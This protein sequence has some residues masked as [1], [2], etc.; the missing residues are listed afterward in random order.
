[1]DWDA[2]LMAVN[3]DPTKPLNEGGV[4]IVKSVQRGVTWSNS[5]NSYQ[6][7]A[8]NEV[9]IKKSIVV[10]STNSGYIRLTSATSLQAYIPSSGAV[11][12]EVVEFY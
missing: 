2:I 12:W 7:L 8:I 5:N 10:S 1:M 3:S 11:S 9:D 4:K 6:T